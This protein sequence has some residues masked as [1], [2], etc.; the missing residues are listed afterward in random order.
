V[1]NLIGKSS[2][3]VSATLP[4]TDLKWM[5]RREATDEAR[6]GAVIR[7]APPPGTQV[8]AGTTVE[9]TVAVPATVEVPK[10]TALAKD[11]AVS[12]LDR[13]SL[14]YRVEERPTSGERPGTVVAQN[15]PAG[16][17]TK[18]GDVIELQVAVADLRT[19]VDLVGKSAREASALLQ[20]ADLKPTWVREATDQVAAGVVL[21]HS[22]AAGARVSPGS[23]V[24]V[25]ISTPSS[26]EVPNLTG[27][28]RSEAADQLK[29]VGLEFKWTTAASRRPA[30]T[31]M[32]QNPEA[33]ARV[34][35]GSAI[36]L[37][38]AT[39]PEASTPGRCIEGYVWREAFAGDRVCVTPEIRAQAAADNQQASRRIEPDPSKRPYG[40][41]TCRQGYVWREA[42]PTDRVCVPPAT[43]AKA[44]E[45]N[46][47]A[48][49][50]VAR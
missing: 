37:T 35:P 19:V 29:R 22:P 32:G 46:R 23:E 42:N 2:R 10:V 16:T 45:D 44:A 33:G 8:K 49:S 6:A 24:T 27:L 20:K 21:R 43:R 11:D 25:T 50:R 36:L 4:Q 9:I 38:V 47:Q 5:I 15:P 28:T 31:I 7:Q 39:S 34:R 13:Q 14:K 1:P 40:P 48:A 17:R 30:G 18:P 26:V 3:D 12:A 41:D